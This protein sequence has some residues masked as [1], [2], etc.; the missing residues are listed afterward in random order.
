[1]KQFDWLRSLSERADFLHTARSETQLPAV[2]CKL[3]NC[4]PALVYAQKPKELNFNE[5]N[6]TSAKNKHVIYRQLWS[7]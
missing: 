1:M 6:F 3:C 7:E 4:M 2:K 5:L